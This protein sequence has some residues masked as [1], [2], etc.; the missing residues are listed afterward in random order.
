K[1]MARKNY[2]KVGDIDKLIH[3]MQHIKRASR[4]FTIVCQH[5]KGRDILRSLKCKNVVYSLEPLEDFA[6]LVSGYNRPVILLYD[7][8]RK[9]NQKCIKLKSLLQQRGVKVNM[10]FRKIIFLLKDR[11]FAGILKDLHRQ[12]GS[13]RVHSGLPV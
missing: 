2:S 11:T 13:E 3:W 9:S 6:D 8:D 4:K 7:G 1:R 12:A 5:K 10:G